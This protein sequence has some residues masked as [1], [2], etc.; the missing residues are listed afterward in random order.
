[1]IKKSHQKEQKA[2]NI[3]TETTRRHPQASD[4][5]HY[6]LNRRSSHF[7]RVDAVAII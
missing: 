6:Y 3:I 2:T 5:R 1:M 7:F 4:H